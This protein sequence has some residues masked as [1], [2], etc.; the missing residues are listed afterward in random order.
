M[1]DLTMP[2][3][4]GSIL[5]AFYKNRISAISE[6][7]DYIHESTDLQKTLQYEDKDWLVHKVKQLLVDILLGFFAGSEWDGAY[8]AQGTIVVKE[9]GKQVAFHIIEIENLKTYLFDSIKL[10]TP[11]T[12]QHRY[13]QLILENDKKL[14]FKLNL[15]L[16][17]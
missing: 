9:T 11:S 10:D 4:I 12:T 15:Q 1:V 16:R 14:Y 8:N 7:V 5:L 13:G 17:F 2:R 6:I 3:I